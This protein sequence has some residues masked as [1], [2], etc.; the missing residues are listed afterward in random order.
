M[1]TGG[2]TGLGFI[3]FNG[4]AA[5]HWSGFSSKRLFIEAAFHQSGFS[6]KRLFIKEAFHQSG[7]SSKR[8]F[9]E[10]LQ[11]Q[12]PNKPTTIESGTFRIKLFTALIEEP[13]LYTHSEKQLS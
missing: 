13:A 2:S 7:F 4:G 3:F 9:I 11:Q 10:K 1:A 5:F 8:L 12:V 6:S